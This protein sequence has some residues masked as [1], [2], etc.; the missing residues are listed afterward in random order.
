[1]LQK[2]FEKIL[3]SKTN[4]VIKNNCFQ[5]IKK[6]FEIFFNKDEDTDQNQHLFYNILNFGEEI[7]N[8]SKKQLLIETYK[9]QRTFVSSKFWSNM[10]D[11][12]KSKVVQF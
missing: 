5:N 11:F 1:M 12:I 2:T 6:V 3:Q 9:E 4:V 7:L 10:F 8:L